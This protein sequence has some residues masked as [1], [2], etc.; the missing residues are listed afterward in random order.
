MEF[1]LGRSD[2]DDPS[3][4]QLEK[5]LF[6]YVEVELCADVDACVHAVLS[7]VLALWRQGDDTFVLI[8]ARTYPTRSMSEPEDD[9]VLRGARDSFVETL[10]FNTALIRRRLRDPRLRMECRKD[11]G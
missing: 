6:P 8:D 1:L 10:V 11:K 4:R 7:G 9:R 5:R 3:M 2:A